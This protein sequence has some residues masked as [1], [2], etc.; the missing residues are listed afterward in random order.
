MGVVCEPEENDPGTTLFDLQPDPETKVDLRRLP[1]L[2]GT[3][4]G[5]VWAAGRRE[6]LV[7]TAL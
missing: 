2:I 4:L 6:F 7:S 3:G 1:K 5:I